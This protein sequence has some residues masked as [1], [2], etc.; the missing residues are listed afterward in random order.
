M[1]TGF[2]EPEATMHHLQDALP[3]CLVQVTTDP[4][5]AA[6]IEKAKVSGRGS[7]KVGTVCFMYTAAS[8]VE[9]QEQC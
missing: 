9:Q 3:G 1:M 8:H 4:K 7:T 5:V 2:E 6:S